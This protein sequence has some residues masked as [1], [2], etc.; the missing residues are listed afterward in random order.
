MAS[1]AQ[2]LLRHGSLKECCRRAG[3]GPYA[4]TGIGWRCSVPLWHFQLQSNRNGAL[5]LGLA[6]PL[7]LTAT[8]V[9]IAKT[10]LVLGWRRSSAVLAALA[11]ALLTMAPLY[12]TEFFSE[13][14]VTFGSSLLMLGFVVWQQRV[15]RGA[16]LI[17]VGTAVAILFR[18]D[19]SSCGSRV[20]RARSWSSSTITIT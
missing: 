2:N 4:V 7:L 13:P 1:V 10:G 9:V 15:A 11:F 16:L 19:S 5:W 12:S 20:D 3:K 17:G 6:N 18:P 14:G 8:T